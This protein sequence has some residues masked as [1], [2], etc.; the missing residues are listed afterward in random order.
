MKKLTYILTIAVLL[1]GCLD[2]P[3]INAKDSQEPTE[4]PWQDYV[5]FWATVGCAAPNDNYSVSISI[6]E[7]GVFE[8]Q[9]YEYTY[10][11]ECT[12]LDLESSFIIETESILTVENE[13]HGL[14]GCVDKVS[15]A[16]FHN[17]LTII[18][19]KLIDYAQNEDGSIDFT[20]YTEYVKAP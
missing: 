19:G 6:S 5:G 15:N 20:G 12:Q 1:M 2:G 13:C 7:S 9:L 17:Y 11:S 14:N 10:G 16:D 18:D 8:I 3:E 4:T